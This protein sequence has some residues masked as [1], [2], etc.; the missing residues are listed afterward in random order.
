MSIFS[1][2]QVSTNGLVF[3][4]DMNNT[5]QS[6]KG[7]P[8]TNKF[9]N[10]NNLSSGWTY[11][12]ATYSGTDKLVETATT[13][14]HY[15]LQN[16]SVTSGL[17]Y[18][19][20]VKA[21]ASERRYIQIFPS[22]GFANTSWTNYDL[23]G[24]T[25]STTGS[26]TAGM[27][28]LGNNEWLCYHTSTATS[29][30]SSGR[31]AIATVL[32]TSAVRAESFLGTTNYGVFLRD[33][34]FEQSSF[35]TPFVTGT[36]TNT[37]AILDLM[38]TYTVTATALTYSSN[39]TFSFDGINDYLS[40]DS[41]TLTNQ[42]TVSVWFKFISNTATWQGLAG[43]WNIT[44]NTRSWLLTK[45]NASN[46]TIRFFVNATGNSVD[47]ISVLTTTNLALNTVYNVVGVYNG[48]T[49]K[50]YVNGIMESTTSYTSTLFQGTLHQIGCFSTQYFT[51]AEIYS[52]SEYNTG[53]TD[54][55][56]KQ[57][58]NALKSRYG[59]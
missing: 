4:Y 27:T 51:D 3:Y 39:N 25:Y 18:T 19:Q 14:V 2:P 33:N 21:T 13:S 34:Q 41:L 32:S 10:P 48:S 54:D 52:V 56:V 11:N 53:L 49:I 57:Q 8:T 38:N 17:A 44:N 30:T 9:T 59:L 45:D 12:A 15:V 23:I 26:D 7:K 36:R 58:F 24:G 43:D 29:S 47:N 55:Q 40:L 16:T 6:W 46:R 22:T 42:L 1:G 5:D 37:Q 50:I 35:P 28:Y 20:S 31:F